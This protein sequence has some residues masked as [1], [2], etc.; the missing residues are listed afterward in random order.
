[1]KQPGA[2]KL[3][4]EIARQGVIEKEPITPAEPGKRAAISFPSST[5]M[6]VSFHRLIEML[7]Y[8]VR[9]PDVQGLKL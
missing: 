4:L 5:Q 8:N 2:D 7:L 3:H 9:G 6:K 1:M